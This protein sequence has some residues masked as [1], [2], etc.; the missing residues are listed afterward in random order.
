MPQPGEIR[1][2]QSGSF[3]WDGAGWKSVNVPNP[4]AG[5]ATAAAAQNDTSRKGDYFMNMLKGAGSALDPRNIPKAIENL[6][7]T[8]RN[9]VEAGKEAVSHPSEILPAF[10]NAD[11]GDVGGAL[12]GLL[13]L[14]AGLKVGGVAKAALPDVSAA[15]AVRAAGKVGNFDLTKPAGFLKPIANAVADRL[16]APSAPEGFDR[17]M[18]NKGNAPRPSVDVSG[19]VTPA[20][21]VEDVLNDYGGYRSDINSGLSPA[22]AEKLNRVK[23]AV[24]STEVKAASA[25]D[26]MDQFQSASDTGVGSGKQEFDMDGVHYAPDESGSHVAQV[27]A[28]DPMEADVP[29]FTFEGQNLNGEPPAVGGTDVPATR[30]YEF[31]PREPRS[32]LNDISEEAVQRLAKQSGDTFAKMR[33]AG[34]F[35][36]DRTVNP[37][38]SDSPAAQLMREKAARGIR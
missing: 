19:V 30:D 6:P 23:A 4:M 16:E 17:F 37:S 33:D 20:K 32:A 14:G 5:D 7:Q 27:A 1:H 3:Q 26:L 24:K 35:D 18:P 38:W 8:A 2:G 21:G 36:G 12:G 31:S 10:E 34:M 15:D 13:G 9:F 29:D 22:L 11:P 25:P 28:P